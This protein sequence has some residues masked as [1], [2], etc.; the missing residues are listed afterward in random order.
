M[1]SQSD[2]VLPNDYHGSSRRQK[3]AAI[4]A[5]HGSHE[6]SLYASAGKP[7]AG[8]AF[9]PPGVGFLLQASNW[10]GQI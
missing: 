2:S 1:I 5:F 9:R 4:N 7:L 3:Q 8:F 10:P 6:I